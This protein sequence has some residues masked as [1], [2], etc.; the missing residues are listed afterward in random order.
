MSDQTGFNYEVMISRLH[1]GLCAFQSLRA[2]RR[3]REQAAAPTE[4]TRVTPDP[5]R[6]T[7]VEPPAAP[8]PQAFVNLGDRAVPTSV[9]SGLFGV[10]PAPPI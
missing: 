1:G 7:R 2:H 10:M 3:Q 4:P 8:P 6:P 5:S 9:D